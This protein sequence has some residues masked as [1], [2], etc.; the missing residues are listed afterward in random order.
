MYLYTVF[1]LNKIA[2][3]DELS[4]FGARDI[5]PG[6]LVEIPFRSQ[7]IPALVVV[8][9][10]LE[11]QKANLKKASFGVRKITREL[12]VSPFRPTFIKSIALLAKYYGIPAALF[13]STIVSKEFFDI[14]FLTTL[15]TLTSHKNTKK[16]IHKPRVFWGK[17]N[18][19]IT[20]YKKQIAEAKAQNKSVFICVP[21]EAAV[22]TL[23]KELGS[24]NE[25]DSSF[26][27]LTGSM[28][29]T[30]RKKVLLQSLSQKT[31]VVYIATPRF[32]ALTG[33]KTCITILEHESATTWISS[34]QNY[35]F[36]WRT[37]ISFL[38]EESG[39]QL[40]YAD[41]RISFTT[42]TYLKNRAYEPLVSPQ[43]DFF[44]QHAKPKKELLLSNRYTLQNGKNGFA[45]FPPETKHVLEN[46]LLRGQNIFIYCL[47]NGFA[48]TF[49][50][51]DCKHIATCVTCAT[52]LGITKTADSTI[53]A[54]CSFCRQK[55]T[56]EEQCTNC[57]SWNLVALGTGIER[58]VSE[59]ENLYPNVPFA[60]V[61]DAY[62]PK[63]KQL[64]T[65]LDAFTSGDVRV[66]IGTERARRQLA[67]KVDVCIVSSF[68]S[69]LAIPH[70]R[71]S[72][73]V[74]EL[75]YELRSLTRETLVLHTNQKNIALLNI[76]D[77][78]S[79]DAWY[80]EEC[81]VRKKFSYPPFGYMATLESD[82]KN[83][84]D[85]HKK[86][87]EAQKILTEQSILGTF[88][89]KRNAKT[90]TITVSFL[91]KIPEQL[92]VPN[93]T[94]VETRNVFLRKLRSQLG[95]GWRVHPEKES[96]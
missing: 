86:I 91:I 18:E 79:Y 92:H 87:F 14:T 35:T 90:K 78:K 64:T 83:P 84:T 43:K 67:A 74:I 55:S 76:Q 15:S 60:A 68:E 26:F 25:T 32:F 29:A 50:C 46:A 53:H 20:E 66:L 45:L 80:T 22:C 85:L 30:A 82:T 72:E 21:T 57:S 39:E 10:P 16:Q 77:Q 33:I 23:A 70:F 4:Y 75:L 62:T 89:K 37:L 24:Y 65:A 31:P 63:E 48:Q 3:A 40:L 19:R 58:V 88:N 49:I 56:V 47:R 42:E 9:E 95:A 5:K 52:P 41:T 12:G 28:T 8:S 44:V 73:R 13:W 81:A 1:P 6:T 54:F 36:D 7:Q 59:F 71:I 11:N 2:Y 94:R 17:L 38:Q 34:F 93:Q 51:N 61:S 27:V 96:F 69:L